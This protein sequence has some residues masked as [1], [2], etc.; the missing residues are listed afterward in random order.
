M[1]IF[2]LF[3][4]IWWHT[5]YISWNIY[6]YN[7]ILIQYD[8]IVCFFYYYFFNMHV[9]SVDPTFSQIK[10]IMH[11]SVKVI[12]ESWFVCEKCF[13]C[14]FNQINATS[15]SIRDLLTPNF[16]V[17]IL[18]LSYISC[19]LVLNIYNK[20]LIFIAVFLRYSAGATE[21]SLTCYHCIF[22]YGCWVFIIN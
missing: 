17:Y 3:H 11:F 5:V 18:Y 16:W 7:C 14:I 21:W 10:L 2:L 4:C 6:S 15:V 1:Q 9:I 12:C 22:N 13:S 20:V 19:Y 8:P